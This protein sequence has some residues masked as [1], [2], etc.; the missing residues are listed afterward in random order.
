MFLKYILFSALFITYPNN[1]FKRYP[2]CNHIVKYVFT[3]DT[4]I[5]LFIY[6]IGRKADTYGLYNTKPNKLYIGHTANRIYGVVYI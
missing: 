3:V 5:K 1:A 6:F 4:F 2:D